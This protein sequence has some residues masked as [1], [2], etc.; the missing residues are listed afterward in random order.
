MAAL[1]AGCANYAGIESHSD[2]RSVDRVHSE[3]TLAKV[4]L[5]KAA[6]PETKWW[7]AFDD[8]MLDALIKQALDN[9]PD[10]E[11][12]RA[13]LRKAN[14]EAGIANAERLPTLDGNAN[15]TRTRVSEVD[16]PTGVGGFYSTTRGML[17]NFSYDVD[18]WGG[19]KAAWEAALGQARAQNIDYR[20]T[21]LSLSTNV[22]Q[23]YIKLQ[24]A[25]TLRQIARANLKR[26][27]RIADINQELSRGGLQNEAPQLQARSSV[28][29]ARQSLASADQQL[30]SA[31]LSLAQLIGKG[32]DGAFALSEPKALTELPL[33]LPGHLP[34]ELLGRRP[35]IVAARWRVEAASKNVKAAKTKF[36][37]NINLS[38]MAGFKS[39]L[40]DYMFSESAKAGSVSPAISL[41]I[42][43]GG[44][45]R[46]NLESTL[47]DYD[48]AVGRYNQTLLSALNQVADAVNAV[49]SYRAQLEA[50]RQAKDA[51]EKA[52]TLSKERYQAGIADY[53]QVL[54]TEQQLLSAERTL[55]TVTSQQ[56]QASIKLIQSL[57]GGFAGD[58]EHLEHDEG[59]ISAPDVPK[60][61][62][63]DASTTR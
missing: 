10:L 9:S 42:F 58:S 38:A 16:D 12:A 1:L 45:L 52:F 19:N 18:L 60:R 14:A 54:S 49:S 30:Q 61:L 44:K 25:Y 2:I 11:I 46:A 20:A 5:S 43:E 53:L 56:Q 3:K 26:T 24:D 23:A 51:A 35:D 40:G 33:V 59:L 28:S 57:G 6:W 34:A 29:S 4:P 15:V 17:L 39:Y 7:R 62:T 31:K 47:A 41:P 48:M 36:F 55:A 13:R 22:A 32:P 8:P 27:Q 50:A 21:L 37:P 63:G